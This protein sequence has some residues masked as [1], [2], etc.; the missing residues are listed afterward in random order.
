MWVRTA[1]SRPTS[2]GRPPIFGSHERPKL[3]SHNMLSPKLG[4]EPGFG[5]PLASV[6]TQTRGMGAFLC[7]LMRVIMTAG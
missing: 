4:I 7:P 6:R 3:D 5:L 2:A 1:S